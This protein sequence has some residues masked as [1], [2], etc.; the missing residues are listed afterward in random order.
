MADETIGISFDATLI[1]VIQWLTDELLQAKWTIRCHPQ[2]SL[3]VLETV[4]TT[5][6]TDGWTSPV[7]CPPS[8]THHPIKCDKLTTQTRAA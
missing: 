6:G 1:N 4:E 8:L 5:A 3:P 7:K 2:P